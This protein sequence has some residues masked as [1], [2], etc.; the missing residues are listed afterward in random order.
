MSKHEGKTAEDKKL[1]KRSRK[2]SR[3]PWAIPDPVEAPL[4]QSLRKEHTE[5]KDVKGPLENNEL[6]RPNEHQG[7]ENQSSERDSKVNIHS[8]IQKRVGCST[9]TVDNR[10]CYWVG[11]G[12]GQGVHLL[13]ETHLFVLPMWVWTLFHAWYNS[14]TCGTRVTGLQSCSRAARSSL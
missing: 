7:S 11:N 12:I 13:V 8:R 2:P 4:V 9:S 5:G 10:P 3:P 6:R 1:L 14:G